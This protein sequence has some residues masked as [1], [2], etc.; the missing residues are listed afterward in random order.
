MKI[1]LQNM[2]FFAYHGVYPDEQKNGNLF[3]V[4]VEFDADLTL[5]E[6]T[7]KIDDTLDY[8]QIY[9][10]IQQEMNI[11]SNL[12]ENVAGRIFSAVKE[13]YP[14]ISFLKV[15]VT[16]HNPPLNGKVQKVSVEKVS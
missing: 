8:E 4:D 11:V 5:A 15:R 1:L 7:D 2:E 3:S 16:K 13:S 14:E 10:I 9:N 12:L 6:R